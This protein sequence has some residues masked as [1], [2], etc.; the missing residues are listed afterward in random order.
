MSTINLRL[1]AVSA[2]PVAVS[3]ACSAGSLP[4]GTGGTSGS[5]QSTDNGSD[6][7]TGGTT[8][9]PGTGGTTSSDLGADL[10]A[11]LGSDLSSTGGGGNCA[12]VL[13]VI[14]RDF[15]SFGDGGLED[16]ELSAVYPAGGANWPSGEY[17]EGSMK[18]N[19]AYKGLNEAGCN[20]VANALGADGK[21]TFNTTI[22]NPGL[23]QKR[24]L[25]P[26]RNPMNTPPVVQQVTACGDWDWG[27]VPPDVI[28]ATTFSQWYNTTANVNME[29]PGE[30]TLTDGVY[31]SSA[32][33]PLDN[34]GFGNTPTYQ[35]NYHFTTEAHVSFTYEM[36]QLFTFR[37]DDD[38]W[39]F[40][41]KKLALD[42]GG[43]HEPMQGT[44]NFDSQAATL[45]IAPGNKYDMDIFHA[46]RQTL[47]SNFRVETNIEC[48]EVVVK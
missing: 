1:I 20:L 18:G 23:G 39:V 33:F 16:F 45:G 25:S 38:L 7:S 9:G 4:V 8:I 42:L 36:G 46:E 48:F 22:A 44:I 10:G 14:Y 37:G 2:L 30:L 3:L 34:Q 19:A 13:P 47:E 31:D 28:G 5:D 26:E 40:V 35:H 6:A 27:W 11:D 43:V 32:F 41:N 21:P 29:V 24:T 12:T 17:G 15:K